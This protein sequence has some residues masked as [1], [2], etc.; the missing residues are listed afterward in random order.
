MAGIYGGFTR[1]DHQFLQN[2][3]NEQVMV[4]C[5]QVCTANAA[6]KQNVPNNNKVA[7][8]I[9]I[10]KAAGSVARRMQDFQF[11]IPKHKDVAIIN[12]NLRQYRFIHIKTKGFAI[13]FAVFQERQTVFMGN[14]LQFVGF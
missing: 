10:A 9:V 1:Q 12:K 6:L 4:A 3:L 5:R 11:L 2:G 13:F 14:R 8:F 7:G